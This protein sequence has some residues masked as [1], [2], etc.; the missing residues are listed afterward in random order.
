[1][2]YLAM[3]GHSWPRENT[4]QDMLSYDLAKSRRH[5]IGALEFSIRHKF[6]RRLGSSADKPPGFPSQRARK[7]EK[8]SI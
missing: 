8:V 4:I 5:E 3:M 2:P 1:M 7:P 6:G